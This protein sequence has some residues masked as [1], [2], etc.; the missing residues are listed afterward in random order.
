MSNVKVYAC[1]NCR[2]HYLRFS[3]LKRH[4]LSKHDPHYYYVSATTTPFSNILIELT[5]L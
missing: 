3:N 4:Q 1:E 2:R 5:S